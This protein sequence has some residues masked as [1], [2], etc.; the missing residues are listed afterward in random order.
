MSTVVEFHFV[1]TDEITLS[2]YREVLEK[3]L[4]SVYVHDTILNTASTCD[5]LVSACNSRLFF[6][7]GSDMDY[8][9]MFD[10]PHKQTKKVLTKF[11]TECPDVFGP[12]KL[13]HLPVGA[14]MQCPIQTRVGEKK[15]FLVVP[16]MFT[17]QNVSST[18]NAYH[19]FKMILELL[20]KLPKKHRNVLVPGL[21]TGVG[22]MTAKESAQQILQAWTDHKNDIFLDVLTTRNDFVFN[23]EVP[24]TQ[25]DIYDNVLY[26]STTEK[27]GKLLLPVT[28]PLGNLITF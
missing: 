9:K 19:A 20:N 13:V 7:G 14:A 16:T 17:P 11:W 5:T 1:N 22:R 4:P 12:C 23:P 15:D 24:G 18:R 28:H 6:D 21:C 27:P 3:H 26:T 2:T 8:M 25:P 10:N